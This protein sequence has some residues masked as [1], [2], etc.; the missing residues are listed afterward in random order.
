MNVASGLAHGDVIILALPH[1]AV[2]KLP[3]MAGKVVL[4]VSNRS[5]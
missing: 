4:D 3:P 1:T 2:S 5:A